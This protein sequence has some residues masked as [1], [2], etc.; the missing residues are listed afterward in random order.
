MR[1][2]LG[3]EVIEPTGASFSF[4]A[5]G[6][7]LMTWL[8]QA[9]GEVD[10]KYKAAPAGMGTKDTPYVMNSFV[11]WS[12]AR[13]SARWMRDEDKYYLVG[14]RL[15]HKWK[16]KNQG[17]HGDGLYMADDVLSG[18]VG[19]GRNTIW[20]DEMGASYRAIAKHLLTHMTGSDKHSFATDGGVAWSQAKMAKLRKILVD[21]GYRLDHKGEGTTEAALPMLAAVMFI[22][23][24]ARNARAFPI[25]LMMLD[26]IGEQYSASETD[27][28]YTW[29][30]VLAHPER[31]D[32]NYKGHLSPAKP[33]KG[34]LQD[35]YGKVIPGSVTTLTKKSQLVTVE[36]KLPASPAGSAS[37]SRFLDLTNDYIQMKE[38][39][40]LCRW[41]AGRL[42]KKKRGRTYY[43]FFPLRPEEDTSGRMS[44]E[45]SD[46]DKLKKVVG[47]TG[48][49]RAKQIRLGLIQE[50]KELISARCKTMAAM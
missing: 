37:S 6:E 5:S 31:L 15:I 16:G 49:A 8:M 2:H 20:H 14:G 25:G 35:D 1:R 36:G 45:W 40:I 32:P 42:K 41:L 39:S 43:G 22:S 28:F 29:D 10:R 48:V 26:M 30:R 50:I 9:I 19:A 7:S 46:E 4:V 18:K 23:E 47:P 38:A 12:R 13:N 44:I 3:I 24:P 34:P 27:K 11:Q 33:Q 21:G 17:G